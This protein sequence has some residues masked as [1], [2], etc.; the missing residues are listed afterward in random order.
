MSKLDKFGPS[1]GFKGGFVFLQ[2]LKILVRSKKSKLIHFN[3]E[4]YET[5]THFF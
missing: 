1:G 2:K 5:S 4:K 3:S